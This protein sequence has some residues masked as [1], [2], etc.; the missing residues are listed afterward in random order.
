MPQQY[1]WNT[2][3]AYKF[4]T[5]FTNVDVSH[6]LLELNRSCTNN[7]IDI[8]TCCSHFEDITLSIAEKTLRKPGKTITDTSPYKIDSRFPPNT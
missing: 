8:D 7:V 1:I 3:S 4:S 6:K 5:Y 2:N